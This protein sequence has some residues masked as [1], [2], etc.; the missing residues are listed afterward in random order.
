[1]IISGKPLQK[2]AAAT[3]P[4]ASKLPLTTPHQ[5]PTVDKHIGFFLA[6]CHRS[7]A[8]FP[9]RVYQYRKTELADRTVDLPMIGNYG[10]CKTNQGTRRSG[11]F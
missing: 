11:N 2:I 8:A 5:L 7:A 9:K 10:W 4:G 6:R 1:V 3:L